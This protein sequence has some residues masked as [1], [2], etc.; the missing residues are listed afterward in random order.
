MEW[1]VI[2]IIIGL[3]PAAIARN[4][5]R[6][7]VGWWVYGAAFF[8][9]ALPHALLIKPKQALIEKRQMAE[10]M[11]KCPFCAEMI[12]SEAKICRYCGRELQHETKQLNKQNES[13]KTIKISRIANFSKTAKSKEIIKKVND[14]IDE[15]ELALAIK[16]STL[17]T[18]CWLSGDCKREKEAR[19]S[20]SIIIN[21]QAY[22]KK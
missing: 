14:K 4:K 18:D 11:K 12:K 3:I 22:S 10:G 2:A 20:G 17:C 13:E 21:C 5:G 15:K 19:K 9:I 1:L 6:N 8:I 7:F 16:K